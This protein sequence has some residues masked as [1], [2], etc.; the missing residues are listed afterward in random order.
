LGFATHPTRTEPQPS[1]TVRNDSRHNWPCPK[2]AWPPSG[3]TLSGS[4]FDGTTS[5]LS[6]N[7]RYSNESAER[8]FLMCRSGSYEFFHIAFRDYMADTGRHLR[9]GESKALP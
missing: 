9:L 7:V 2:A 8:F 3:T 1:A 4:Y 6:D 5:R